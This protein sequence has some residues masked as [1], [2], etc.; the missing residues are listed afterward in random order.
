[1]SIDLRSW[2]REGLLSARQCFAQAR[3]DEVSN[4]VH[5]AT[6]NNWTTHDRSG[7]CVTSIA[8]PYGDAQLFER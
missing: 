1:M 2:H 7:S 5:L 8:G 3:A 4:R 6:Q